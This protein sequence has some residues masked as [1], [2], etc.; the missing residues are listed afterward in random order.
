MAFRLTKE[1]RRRLKIPAILNVHVDAD[2]IIN[3][4]PCDTGKCMVRQ[5]IKKLVP[6]AGVWVDGRIVR[7]KKDGM[8]HTSPTPAIAWSSIAAYD[9]GLQ[10]KPFSFKLKIVNVRPSRSIPEYRKIQI[11]AARNKR[12]AEGR[13]DKRYYRV[14]GRQ[15]TRREWDHIRNKVKND[16]ETAVA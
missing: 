15:V 8:I 1:E 5:A 4:H 6:D 9:V 3:S 14:A 7:I 12:A 13:P 10:V 11:N 16:I 2:T